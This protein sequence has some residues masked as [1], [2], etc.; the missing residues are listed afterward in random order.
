MGSPV[1]VYFCS[2]LYIQ[3]PFF[4]LLCPVGKAALSRSQWGRRGGGK[5]GG[6][7]RAGRHGPKSKPKS[8]SKSKP[9]SK[10]RS[11]SPNQSPIPRWTSSPSPNQSPIPIWTSSPSPNQSPTKNWTSSPSP[12]QSPTK[13]RDF[14]SK[15]KQ[16]DFKVQVQADWTSCASLG[17]GGLLHSLSPRDIAFSG[18]LNGF[19]HRSR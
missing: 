9:K 13:V 8:K 12:T 10:P 17:G 4:L 7:G 18:G 11:P 19:P 16:L 14:K 2:F 3:R 1:A 5:G 6:K 15:S